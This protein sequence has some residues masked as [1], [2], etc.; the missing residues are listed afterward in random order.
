LY[1]NGLDGVFYLEDATLRRE[2]VDPTIV[3][4]PASITV[5]LELNMFDIACFFKNYLN[6]ILGRSTVI[7]CRVSGVMH[8]RGWIVTVR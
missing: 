6:I 1:L 2:G 7:I 8:I 5:Y 3:I 4:A